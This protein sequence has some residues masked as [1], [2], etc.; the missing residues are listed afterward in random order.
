MRHAVEHRVRALF[1]SHLST[2]LAQL[3]SCHNCHL[4]SAPQQWVQDRTEFPR[5][6][7]YPAHTSS[8]ARP[9]QCHTPF[10]HFCLT[11]LPTL[12]RL[13]SG[14]SPACSTASSPAARPPMRCSQNIPRCSREYSPC[15]RPTGATTCGTGG[16]SWKSMNPSLTHR[17]G[18]GFGWCVWGWR[19]W[20][21]VVVVV[22]VG[23]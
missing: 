4:S 9:H 19:G 17:C 20:R 13:R 14:S 1:T 10:S 2:L 22:K 7:C 3:L 5:Y 21:A 12:S 11:P 18:L 16:V 6:A 15:T 8:H 23:S